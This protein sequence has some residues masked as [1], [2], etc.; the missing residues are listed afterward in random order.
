MTNV[1]VRIGLHGAAHAVV[2]AGGGV[3]PD[4]WRGAECAWWVAASDRWHDPRVE[5]SV[6]QRRID[7]TPVVETKLAVPGGDV[8]HRTFVVADRGGCLVVQV[9]ND[10]P[11]PV[12]VAVPVRE[13]STTAAGMGTAPQGIE[14]PA[15]VQVFPLAHRSSLTFAWPLRRSRWKPTAAFDAATLPS[16]EQVVRGWVQ[17]CD[18]ASRMSLQHDQFVAARS[19]ILLASASDIDDVLHDDAALGVLII[20]ERVRMGDPARTWVSPVADAVRR[21]GR[22]E[23]GTPLLS[24]ALVAAAHILHAGDEVVGASDV[25]NV[26]LQVAERSRGATPSNASSPFNA[27]GL[28]AAVVSVAMVEDQLVRAIAPHEAHVLP[29]SIPAAWRGVNVEAHGLVASPQHRVSLALRWHGPNVALLWEVDGPPGL[30]LRAPAV[31]ARFSS[32]Q[33]TGEALLHVSP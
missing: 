5:P 12:A 11:E 13:L 21:L 26:W 22:T 28:A 2:G 9:S 8:V 31:D 3:H 10:S 14:L 19:E 7:G 1:G 18:R 24:R 20:G 16:Y 4:G 29:A 33:Q 25:V 27:N 32:T 6:R 23:Q 17:T 30:Q 15:G